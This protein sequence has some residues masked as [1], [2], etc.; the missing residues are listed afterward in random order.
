MGKGMVEPSKGTAR[1]QLPGSGGD[2]RGKGLRNIKRENI[3]GQG[4]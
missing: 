1:E 4:G 2:G 3:K